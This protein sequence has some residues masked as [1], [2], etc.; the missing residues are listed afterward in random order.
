MT[1][2]VLDLALDIIELQKFST[3]LSSFA[4]AVHLYSTRGTV[5][6]RPHLVVA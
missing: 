1:P 5:A 2:L 3:L 4:L 6:L